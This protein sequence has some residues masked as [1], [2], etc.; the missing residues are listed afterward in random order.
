MRLIINMVAGR[1]ELRAAVQGAGDVRLLWDVASIPDFRQSLHESHYDLLAGVYMALVSNG[2]LAKD[3]VARAIQQLDRVDGDLDT[4]MTRLAYIR[5]W[6][7]VTNRSDW[8]DTPLEWQDRT[9]L[10]EDKL[11]DR[12]H[13]RLSERFVDKRT[14]HLS[15]KL[16]ETKN[17]I[18]SVKDDGTVLVE[19]EEVG[20]LMGFVFNP[21]LADGE[22]KATILAAARRGLPDEI[23]RRVQAFVA[24]AD[25][26]FQIDE[27]G[28]VLWREATIAQ[29]VKGES[30]YLPRANL[31]SSDLL[32]IDQTQRMQARL[33]NFLTTHIK[34]VLGRLITLATPDQVMPA[35]ATDVKMPD[36]KT[37]L[38]EIPDAVRKSPANE[39]SDDNTKKGYLKLWRK[40]RSVLNQ[41]NVPVS[42]SGAA[43]GIAYMVFERLGSVPTSDVAHLTRNMQETDKPIL[44]SLGLRFGV[45]TVYA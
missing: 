4:L 33:S 40:Q 42:L 13:Q 1:K 17:L 18:T 36:A 20:Q 15:R 39:A 34:S 11:S 32:S 22:E 9:R 28:V 7:Y 30:L 31:A 38:V 27:K 37:T 14:A 21:T 12:L 35:P 10:I 23:E 19:G 41:S 16:R 24:S 45:E 25:A 43:K 44:A 8:T 26:A 3:T 29:L 5:T 2:V 6:T